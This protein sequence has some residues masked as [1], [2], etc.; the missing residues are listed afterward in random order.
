[1]KNKCIAGV[2]RLELHG[3]FWMFVKGLWRI[4]EWQL[5]IHADIIRTHTQIE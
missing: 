2:Y 4:D 1:L 3:F 5:I